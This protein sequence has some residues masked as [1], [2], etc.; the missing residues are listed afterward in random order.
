[1]SFH[2][3]VFKVMIASPGDVVKERG[4]IRDALAK[5]NAVNSESRGIVLLPV[6]WETHSTPEMGDHPQKILN[7]QILKECDLLVG[8]FWTRIGTSTDDYPSGT[9]EE[10]EEHYKTGKP[11]MIYFSSAQVKPDEIDSKQYDEL[12][13]FKDSLNKRS[14]YKTYSDISEFKSLFDQDL[15]IKLNKD[16]YSTFAVHKYHFFSQPCWETIHK[17]DE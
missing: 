5:W 16:P 10:I 14:L 2:A 1:M 11:L 13:K 4:I 9:V 15:S 8:V 12:K 3:E 6:G 17:I 7:K